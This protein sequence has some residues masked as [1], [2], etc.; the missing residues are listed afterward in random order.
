MVYIG[1]HISRKST[2]IDTINNII[3]NGGNAL[4]IF[5]SN[6]RSTKITN[7]NINFFG[8]LNEIKTYINKNKFAIVIHNPYTINL[9]MSLKNGKK[10]IDINECYWIQLIINELKI[11]HNM[12]S[13][14]CIIHTGKYTTNTKEEGIKNMKIAIKYIINEIIKLNLN[15]KLILETSSGQGT[16]LFFNYQDF[17]DFYN[18]FTKKEKNYFKI[19]IDTCHIWASGYELEEIY[20]LTIK[21]NNI[22][23]IAVIHI[24]NSKNP[25]NS[26]LDR[27]SEMTNKDGYIKINDIIYFINKMKINI[28]DLII[29]LETPSKNFKKEIELLS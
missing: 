6:P 29:I 9:A 3:E 27:H 1:A 16:E 11:A 12:N 17:L 23:D 22:N 15:S 24:N 14:G 5:V 20:E 18:S 10:I 21:N 7:L 8:D 19:C 28:K 13:Y 25:K 26:H 4:Q 2:I